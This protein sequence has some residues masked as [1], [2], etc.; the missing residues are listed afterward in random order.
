M[1]AAWKLIREQDDLYILLLVEDR[2]SPQTNI[3][4][5]WVPD[6][7][8]TLTTTPIG[9]HNKLR[10][11]WCSSKGIQWLQPIATPRNQLSIQGFF[12]DKIVERAATLRE[13]GVFHQIATVLAL[14]NRLGCSLYSTGIS[15]TEA[16]WRTIIA[17][18]YRSTPASLQTGGAFCSFMVFC[19]W[20]LDDAA[21]GIQD[22]DPKG[23]GFG[24]NDPSLFDHI[25]LQNIH[26]ETYIALEMLASSD[27]SGNVPDASVLAAALDVLKGPPNATQ[28]DMIA[29]CNQYIGSM[30]EAYGA[31]RLFRTA[32]NFL[33]IA[34]H[35]LLPNDEI[36]I[37]AGAATPI[38]LRPAE[39]DRFT[40]VGEAYVHG[41]MFGEATLPTKAQ[42]TKRIIIV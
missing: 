9:G 17:D 39:Q 36:W 8:A 11:R 18:T 16:L 19:L 28:E 23:V 2:I 22:F 26:K 42:M 6:W 32:E 37:A 24:P 12:F 4:P 29:G 41:T 14:T 21:L 7:S 13:V 31:R 33:G 27:T 5:S 34:S 35:S 10:R 1:D 38:I 40:L 3:L 15:K 25:E 20:G 30:S